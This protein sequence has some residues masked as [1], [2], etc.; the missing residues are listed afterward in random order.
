[1][2]IF[3]SSVM[4][5]FGSFRDSA[6][7]ACRTLR[8]EPIRAEDFG[9]S[10][11]S[12]QRVCLA[13][14]RSS[15]AV[16]LL[17]GERYG[18]PAEGSVLSPT[19]EEYREARNRRP[20]LVFIQRVARTEPAQAEFIREV[21]AWSRGH[22]TAEFSDAS[23]LN[24]AVTQA[25]HALELDRNAGPV[26]EGEIQ[27]RLDRLV[28][29]DS[30]AWRTSLSV[31]VVGAPR[32]Q[33]VRPSELERPGLEEKLSQMAMFGPNRVMDRKAG[34]ESEVRDHAL[35]LKQDAGEVLLDELGTIR[36]IQSAQS[37]E[38]GHDFLPVVIEEEILDRIAAALRFAGEVLD[39]VDPQRRLSSVAPMVSLLGAGHLGW[40]TRQQRAKGGSVSMGMS[41]RE[42]I[43]AKLNP[44]TRHRPA[45]SQQSEVLAE[46][47]MVLLRRQVKR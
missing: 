41:G 15:D 14:V 38:R 37:D 35:L 23:D 1:M 34:S 30:G 12:P 33:V 46:D 6:A 22:Y 16:V 28:P 29:R 39:E 27:A 9:A 42:A 7:R 43:S 36:V 2:K 18:V 13:E 19:H 10:P 40:Q 11:D 32:Q 20:V 44:M 45:L 4:R 17:L 8:H 3:I 5:D 25:V 24:E 47:L 21:Q 31:I 26:D